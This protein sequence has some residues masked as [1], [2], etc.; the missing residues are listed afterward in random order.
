LISLDYKNNYKLPV[1]YINMTSQ[2][3]LNKPYQVR[4][5]GTNDLYP[6]LETRE[7]PPGTE[8]AMAFLAEG[9]SSR[10]P[11]LHPRKP[12][13]TGFSDSLDA[14]LALESRRPENLRLGLPIPRERDRSAH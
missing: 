3:S 11:S 6:F 1:L 14:E 7:Q 4:L 12:V 8:V 9:G 5:A 10:T 13:A 2:E